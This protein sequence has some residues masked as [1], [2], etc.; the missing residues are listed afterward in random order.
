MD[1]YSGFVS[2]NGSDLSDDPIVMKSVINLLNKSLEETKLDITMETL[3]LLLLKGGKISLS[4][5]GDKLKLT[6]DEGNK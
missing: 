5:E 4:Y 3:S 2:V 6:I 1:E